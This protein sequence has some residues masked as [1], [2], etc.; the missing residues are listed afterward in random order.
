[1][2]GYWYAS[3]QSYTIDPRTGKKKYT[4]IHWGTLTRD[5]KFYPN[6]TFVFADQAVRNK[7]IYPANWNLSPV[8]DLQKVFS[9][10]VPVCKVA[11]VK[12]LEHKKIKEIVV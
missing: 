3:T 12:D 5:L 4:H 6:E 7:L 9:N 11:R 8:Y 1:M 10:I 2:N